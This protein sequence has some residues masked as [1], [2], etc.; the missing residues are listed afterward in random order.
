MIG[1]IPERTEQPSFVVGGMGEYAEGLIS[2]GRDHDVIIPLFRPIGCIDE[3]TIAKPRDTRDGRASSYPP[4]IVCHDA[5][6]ICVAATSDSAP[7]RSPRKTQQ[8]MI[9]VK[10]DECLRREIED[11]ARRD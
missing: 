3:N 9:V 5:L 4:T 10:L 11:I 6:H 8:A 1:L 2:V 7:K